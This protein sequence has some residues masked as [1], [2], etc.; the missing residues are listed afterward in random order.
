MSLYG[1]EDKPW[2][3]GLILLFICFIY[4]MFIF[5]QARPA[6]MFVQRPSFYVTEWKERKPCKLSLSCSMDVGSCSGVSEFVI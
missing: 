2:P 5:M 3:C 6:N 4:N 1:I